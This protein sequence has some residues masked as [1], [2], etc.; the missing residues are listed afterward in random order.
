MFLLFNVSSTPSNTFVFEDHTLCPKW[1]NFNTIVTTKYKIKSR[2]KL[3]EIHEITLFSVTNSK[4]FWT[5]FS[6]R[7]RSNVE[8]FLI[9]LRAFVPWNIPYILQSG[10]HSA[11]AQDVIYYPANWGCLR[12]LILPKFWSAVI[13]RILHGLEAYYRSDFYVSWNIFSLEGFLNGF[14]LRDILCKLITVSKVQFSPTL[15]LSFIMQPVESFWE[16]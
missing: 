2:N 4:L 1:P 8:T 16:V 6:A 7:R 3:K 14:V 12:K 13:R 10:V 9:F 11:H 5:I 15:Q